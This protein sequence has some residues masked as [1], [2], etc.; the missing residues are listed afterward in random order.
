MV[1]YAELYIDAGATFNDTITIADDVTSANLNLFSYS[2]ETIKLKRAPSSANAS[3]NISAAIIDGP[4]GQIQMTMTAANTS[5]MKP[6]RYIYS[7]FI[8]DGATVSKI[9]EGT[10][11]VSPKVN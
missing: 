8:S 7:V 5:L 6:G 1:A 9:M 10:V 2:V 4:N 11:F 3:G